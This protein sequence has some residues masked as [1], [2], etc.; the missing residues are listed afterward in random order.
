MKPKF[1]TPDEVAQYAKTEKF[2]LNVP[3]VYLDQLKLVADQKKISVSALVNE[4]IRGY[5]EF[6]DESKKE[7]SV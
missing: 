1:R 2:N 5:C 7:P 3:K 4:A 6:L